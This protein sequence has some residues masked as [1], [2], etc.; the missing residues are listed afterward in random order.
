M[1]LILNNLIFGALHSFL[2]HFSPL[3]ISYLHTKSEPKAKRSNFLIKEGEDE[4][5]FILFCSRRGHSLHNIPTNDNQNERK[6]KNSSS[7][8]CYHHLSSPN[9][10]PILFIYFVVKC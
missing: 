7:N 4:Q 10:L 9:L 3:N 8:S 5:H 1:F 2:N 6:I